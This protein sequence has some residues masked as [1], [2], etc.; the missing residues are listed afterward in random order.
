M[1]VPHAELARF[2]RDIETAGHDALDPKWFEGVIPNFGTVGQVETGGTDV[3]TQPGHVSVSQSVP[4][5]AIIWYAAKRYLLAIGVIGA[6]LALG[7]LA[8]QR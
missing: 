4:H 8:V 3:G 5:G 1:V 2:D 6:A 7:I